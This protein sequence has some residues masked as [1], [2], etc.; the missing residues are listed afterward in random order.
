MY[1]T[2]L[3]ARFGL[4][5][6]EYELLP[7]NSNAQPSAGGAATTRVARLSQ[8]LRFCY[9]SRLV[10]GG[11]VLLVL[12]PVTPPA[13]KKGKEWR[14]ERELWASGFPDYADVKEYERLLPQHNLHLEWP[15]GKNG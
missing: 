3:A 7:T 15:E 5:E 11:I 1:F 14:A 9:R 10:R 4:S 8:Y 6:G 13:Y 12:I 2:W